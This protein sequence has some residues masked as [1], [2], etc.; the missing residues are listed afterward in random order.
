MRNYEFKPA[1]KVGDW[2]VRTTEGSEEY[3]FTKGER[4]QIRRIGPHGGV[5]VFNDKGIEFSASGCNW[6]STPLFLKG[7]RIIRKTSG[8]IRKVTGVTEG[9]IYT[10]VKDMKA[11]DSS[12]FI[13]NDFGAV[14]WFDAHNFQL[15]ND[16]TDK[17]MEKTKVEVSVDFIKQAHKAACDEWK[18]KIEKELPSLFVKP[19]VHGDKFRMK[20]HRYSWED[21]SEGQNYLLA[22][23]QNKF[24]LINLKT[25]VNFSTPEDT[26]LDLFATIA[27]TGYEFEKI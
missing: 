24:T 13:I 7:Q 5:Y 20:K 3:P 12:V 23:V 25:G 19:F 15:I 16:K 1:V 27:R 11:G 17:T 2:I 9:W 21:P 4:Y 14:D 22:T 10:V 26:V 18:K 6:A 8:V